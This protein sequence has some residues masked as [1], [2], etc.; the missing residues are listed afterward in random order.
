MPNHGGYLG[1]RFKSPIYEADTI[2]STMI[3]YP[4]QPI[5]DFVKGQY[6]HKQ[7]DNQKI[8]LRDLETDT[9]YP[10]TYYQPRTKYEANPFLPRSIKEQRHPLEENDQNPCDHS[11]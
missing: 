2:S 10:R 1:S 3:T 6:H 7:P 9:Q 4:A 5:L 8:L 11:G